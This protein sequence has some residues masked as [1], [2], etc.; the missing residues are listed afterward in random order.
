MPSTV[1]DQRKLILI[2]I[3]SLMLPLEIKLIEVHLKEVELIKLI[4]IQVNRSPLSTN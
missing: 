4:E 2:E 3:K 1:E